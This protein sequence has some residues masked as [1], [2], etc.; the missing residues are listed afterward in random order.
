V[1][2]AVAAHSAAALFSTQVRRPPCD[3]VLARL[4]ALTAPCFRSPLP[5]P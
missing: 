3:D 1:T 4:L 2:Y 5:F